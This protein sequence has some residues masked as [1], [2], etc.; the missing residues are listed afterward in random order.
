MKILQKIFKIVILYAFI[1]NYFHSKQLRIYSI[2]R[3]KPT[4]KTLSEW[5]SKFQTRTGWPT[6]MV[7][8]TPASQASQSPSLRSLTE[9]SGWCSLQR[10]SSV[11]RSTCSPCVIQIQLHTSWVVSALMLRNSWKNT[12]NALSSSTTSS[13][14]RLIVSTPSFEHSTSQPRLWGSSLVLRRLDKLIVI[15]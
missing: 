11:A 3:S 10:T 2:N 14:I 4:N 15:C 1:I 7:V 6:E 12:R 9:K 8:N 13:S 5:I